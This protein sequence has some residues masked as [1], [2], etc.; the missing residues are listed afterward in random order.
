MK[1]KEFLETPIGLYR[2]FWKSGGSSLAAIGMDNKGKRWVACANW[3]SPATWDGDVIKIAHDI[4]SIS[5]V[6][7][8]NG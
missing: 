8:D 3:T 1:I 4:S 2:L 7:V 6:E 5:L